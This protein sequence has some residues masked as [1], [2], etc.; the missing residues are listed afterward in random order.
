LPRLQGQD[1]VNA[2]EMFRRNQDKL[3]PDQVQHLREIYGMEEGRDERL[4]APEIDPEEWER[5]HDMDKAMRTR[6]F[7]RYE[8]GAADGGAIGQAAQ[9]AHHM[10][11]AG[12]LPLTGK[13]GAA[14]QIPFAGPL[15][16]SVPG[17]TD[18]IGLDVKAGSYV[19]P[20]DSVSIMGESNTKAGFNAVKAMF[21][22]LDLTG[23]IK[24]PSGHGLGVPPAGG[25]HALQHM[26]PPHG[27][28]APVHLQQYGRR[29]QGG[30]TDWPKFERGARPSSN[31]EDVRAPQQY[32]A[33][34]WSGQ[35]WGAGDNPNTFAGYE[36][37]T[38]A[39]PGHPGGRAA[40][41]ETDDVTMGAVKDGGNELV[42]IIAAGGE[43]VVSPELIIRKFGS[44]EHGHKTMDLVVKKLRR[45]EI[46]RLRNAPAPKT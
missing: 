30:G 39:D 31:V 6:P 12:A 43:V 7:F 40:G 26:K 11:H 21:S 27:H 10:A 38:Y 44:L 5:S 20:A 14:A 16:S 35:Y 4:R 41:G 18:R 36:E 37:T 1:L 42:P 15:H 29:A 3:R 9:L 34:P 19:M 25:A 13:P 24:M 28:P 33:N 32:L 17:R 45:K 23:G 8:Q 46:E 22:D 2:M